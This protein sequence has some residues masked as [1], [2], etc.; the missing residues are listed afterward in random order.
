[1]VVVCFSVVRV[2]YWRV[3]ICGVCFLMLC[4]SLWCVFLSGMLWLATNQVWQPRPDG[5]PANWSLPLPVSQ[6]PA[7]SPLRGALH[8]LH[9]ALSSACTQLHFLSAT[10]AQVSQH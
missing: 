6:P 9:S 1:M 7:M 2:S 10:A 5:F 4:V 3:F 8:T